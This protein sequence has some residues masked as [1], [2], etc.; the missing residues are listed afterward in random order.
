MLEN[1]GWK[2]SNKIN[3]DVSYLITNTPNS[4]TSKNKEADR[5]GITKI[6]EYDFNSKILEVS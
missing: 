1:K 4:G 2:V 5:L 6:T 3:K